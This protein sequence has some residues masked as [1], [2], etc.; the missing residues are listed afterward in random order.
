[1]G[2]ARP[3]HLA[4]DRDGTV[5]LSVHVQ[6]N[7]KRDEIVGPHGAALKVKV[8]AP[9]V[10]GKANRAVAELLADR[11]GVPPRSVE[12]VTGASIRQKRFRIDGLSLDEAASRLAAGQGRLL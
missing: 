1:V 6:P 9:P 5:I 7:A 2:V 4:V 10:G 8:T 12:L 11:L 3:D